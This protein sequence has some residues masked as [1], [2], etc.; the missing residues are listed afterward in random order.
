MFPGDTMMND[1]VHAE[2]SPGEAVIPR[3]TVAQNPEIVSSL[4]GRDDQMQTDFRD[5]ATLLKAMRSIRMGG[6]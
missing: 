2:L 4:L 1:T 3:S 5:V 6:V